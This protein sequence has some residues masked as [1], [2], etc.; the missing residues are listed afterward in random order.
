MGSQDIVRMSLTN[1]PNKNKN[2]AKLYAKLYSFAMCSQNIETIV[3]IGRSIQ[4]SIAGLIIAEKFDQATI[5]YRSFSYRFL[6]GRH[7]TNSKA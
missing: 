7:S 3:T 2:Q 1:I 5:S 4:R 6:E